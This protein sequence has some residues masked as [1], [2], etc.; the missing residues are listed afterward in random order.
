MIFRP[1]LAALALFPAA[2][3]SQTSP[4]PERD[5]IVKGRRIT[6]QKAAERFVADISV[7]QGDQL[8]RF[9]QPICPIVIGLSGPYGAM[10]EQRIR[11]TAAAVGA[12]VD[13]AKCAANLIVV[14]AGSGAALVRDIRKQRPGWLEGLAGPEIDALEAP[15]PTRAWSVNSLRN[16]DGRA[17]YIPPAGSGAVGDPLGDKPTLRVMSASI[18]KRPFRQDMEASFVVIDEKATYGLTLRQLADYVVM[19]SLAATRAPRSGGA[20]LDTILALFDPAAGHPRGLSDPD[21]AY[22]RALYKSPG[23]RDTIN[24]RAMIARRMAAGK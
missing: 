4:P 2:A 18:I 5:V 10:V 20:A 14:F 1:F 13:K 15:G 19:R 6:D 8:A 7:R 9:H 16:E 23:T 24:E 17:V 12:P 21:A 22:L 3:L 11:T